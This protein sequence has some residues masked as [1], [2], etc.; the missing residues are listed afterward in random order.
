MHTEYSDIMERIAEPPK[1][2]DEHAVPRYCDFSP[3]E[4]ADIYASEALLA[5]IACQGCER[6]FLVAMSWCEHDG[7]LRKVPAPSENRSVIHYGDP[8]NVSC[9][10]AGP[11]MNSVPLRVVE[12][13]SRATTDDWTRVPEHEGPLVPWWTKEEA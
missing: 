1:W 5:E 4:V 3:R 11:T 10:A 8:P 7:L 2:F 6:R 9:C 13:W 12:F